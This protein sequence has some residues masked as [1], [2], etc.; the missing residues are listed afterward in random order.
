MVCQSTSSSTGLTPR[1]NTPASCMNG[2]TTIAADS[3]PVPKPSE[4]TYE[5]PVFL[6]MTWAF[7][8]SYALAM[9][10]SHTSQ[11]IIT[12]ALACAAVAVLTAAAGPAVAQSAAT[13]LRFRQAV[14]LRTPS[15]GRPGEGVDGFACSS[16]GNCVASVSVNDRN[17][18]T[19]A[20]LIEQA[21][22]RW[23]PAIQVKLPSD[24]GRDP[25]AVA[26]DIA[27]PRAAFC[28]AVG[29]YLTR[30]EGVRAFIVTQ[31]RGQWGRARQPH[32][33]ANV[34]AA[35]GT[36]LV[37]IACTA[38]G[39][40]EAVGGYTDKAQQGEAM[41]VPEVRGRWL[42]A[43]EIAMP[44][45]ADSDP[46]ATLFQVACSR[47]GD[48]ETAGQY[49]WQGGQDAAVGVTEV[50]GRWGRGAAIRLPAGA[51]S[52]Q[53]LPPSSSL[54]AIACP[55]S[56]RC[57]GVG[58][59]QVNDAYLGMTTFVSGGRWTRAARVRALPR[60]VLSAT[61]NGIACPGPR[62]CAAVGGVLTSGPSFPVAATWN[63]SRWARI[64]A[65]KLP[66]NA[67][68]GARIEASLVAVACPSR[69]YCEA[70]GWYVDKSGKFQA[71]AVTAS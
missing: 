17:G 48:C 49:Q 56:D 5:S 34:A 22:G 55:R 4:S 6:L 35:P 54:F 1:E 41:A 11:P 60:A 57:L 46:E 3:A 65:G 68:T 51:R 30:A 2:L 13:T 45:D 19:Q 63:G 32:A 67:L 69:G 7:R 59:Y 15:I 23:R 38:P 53:N 66:A 70:L 28:V 44:A 33:P 50:N 24:A 8:H 64:A 36:Y 29:R 21:R 71:M 26:E 25:Y 62:L 58:S 61:L 42:G 14:E 20:Y 27:C 43:T 47:P 52:D 10:Q 18:N 37:G 12:S 31:V 9:S 16:P 40:C 39:S